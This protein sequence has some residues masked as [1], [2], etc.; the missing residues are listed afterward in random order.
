MANAKKCDRCGAYYQEV[1]ATVIEILT[2]QV[3]EMFESKTV[4]QNIAVIEKFLDFCPSCSESLKRWVKGKED[5]E[6]GK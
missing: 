3:T 2:K 4:L 6:D 1:E 5:T